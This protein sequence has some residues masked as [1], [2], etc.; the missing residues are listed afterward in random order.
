L[1]ACQTTTIAKLSMDTYFTRFPGFISGLVGTVILLGIYLTSFYNYLLFHSLAEFFS[2]VIGCGIFMVAW[3]GQ[4]FLNNDYL[5]FLGTAYLFVAGIDFLHTLSYSG[6]GVFPNYDTNLPTQ[7]WIVARYLESFSLVFAFFFLTSKLRPVLLMTA[8]ALLCTFLLLSIFFWNIFP[9]CFVE[10]QGLTA[11]KKGSEYLISLIL[12]VALWL[13]F[14]NRAKFDPQVFRL[15]SAS[16]LMTIGAELAFTFYIHVYGISNLIGHYFKIISFYFIYRAIIQTGLIRPYDLLFRD[17]SKAHDNLLDTNQELVT[18]KEA[19]D[20]ANRAKS[21]FLANMSHE[22]RTPLH[23]IL[24][25]SQLM[26]RESA[27]TPEQRESL[28][29]INR[30]G[31]HLLSLINDVLEMSKI[32]AGRMILNEESIDL[33][34]TLKNIAEMMRIRAENKG[35]QFILEHELEPVH[36]VKIDAGKLRQILINLIGNAIKFTKEGG[37]SLRVQSQKSNTVP[38]SKCRLLFEIE[39]TGVGIAETNLNTIFDAFVQV[40]STR[41]ASEGTGLGLPIT[42]HY[43][44]LMGGDI[45]VTS[46]VGEGSIFKFHIPVTLANASDIETPT[47]LRHIIGLAPNQPVP[48]ILIVEDSQESRLLLKKLLLKV[49]FEVREASHGKEALNI[50]EQWHPHLIWMDMRMPV[51]DGYE[52]TKRIKDSPAGRKT[53]VI[54]LTASAFERQREEI[55]ATGCDDFVRKPFREN[56]ILELMAQYLNVQYLYETV[57]LEKT[58]THKQIKSEQT[59]NPSVLATISDNLLDELR[60]ALNELDV[61][62]VVSAINRIGEQEATL[63]KAMMFY[64]DN[65]QYEQL[66]TF[67]E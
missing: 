27:V 65:F 60:Q 16:M 12:T 6:M 50:F 49:G 45:E 7:L 44:Q 53:V 2:I 24:G 52:A 41:L 10:G 39:D 13:L 20:A 32:E 23:A 3:N 54:A 31:E 46:R 21:T 33:H 36:L 30:S 43:I 57:L 26:A 51:M 48:R 62:A 64:A 66:A 35:L 11:F 29:I 61:D 9:T 42:H 18:A 59:L 4:R 38:N 37:V 58:D 63:A 40:G 34:Q 5:L 8:Y 22:L 28:E 67:L 19:A 17:L 47:N 1:D 55:L 25:F 56:N 15:M 14:R